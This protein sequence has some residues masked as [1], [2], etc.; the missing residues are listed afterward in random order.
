MS[1]IPIYQD[2]ARMG[3]MAPIAIALSRFA[4]SLSPGGGFKKKEGDRK[5][6]YRPNNFVTFE[7]Q[8]RKRGI[9]L[10]L[11]GSLPYYKDRSETFPELRE[12]YINR[13]E[14][15]PWEYCSYPVRSPSQLLAAAQFIKWAFEVRKSK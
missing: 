15:G 2:F 11:R 3:E 1:D 13:L 6:I 12:E 8:P 4:E 10:T 5:W 7:V 9:L 14:S